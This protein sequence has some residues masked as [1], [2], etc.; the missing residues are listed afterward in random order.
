MF[1]SLVL[2]HFIN[3]QMKKKYFHTHY[4]SLRG[5]CIWLKKQSFT[6][7]SYFH[8]ILNQ[9]KL[10]VFVDTK[11]IVMGSLDVNPWEWHCFGHEAFPKGRKWTRA[12]LHRLFVKQCG[13]HST[14]KQQRRHIP[15]FFNWVPQYDPVVVWKHSDP[16]LS[17]TFRTP[18]FEGLVWLSQE[19]QTHV[20][21][22]PWAL[23]HSY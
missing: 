5:N 22:Y 2:F 14:K 13:R 15:F 9:Q 3:D 1:F 4:S 20:E 11:V 21:R 17:S 6:L 7:Q 23:L 16:D 18:L 10:P 19:H 8:A 12:N